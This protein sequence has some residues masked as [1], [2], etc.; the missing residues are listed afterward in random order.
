MTRLV[1]AASFFLGPS[2][3]F[4]AGIGGTKGYIFTVA[5]DRT[6]DGGQALGTPPI[7]LTPDGL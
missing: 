1:V 4:G 2:R 6:E 5:R 7:L 3:H